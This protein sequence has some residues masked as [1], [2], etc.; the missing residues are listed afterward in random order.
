MSSKV[1]VSGSNPARSKLL[2]L[3]PSIYNFFRRR[4]KFRTNEN[5]RN[6]YKKNSSTKYQIRLHQIEVHQIR[7]HQIEVHQIEVHQ[8]GG[9]RFNFFGHI[10]KFK[11]RTLKECSLCDTLLASKIE[12]ITEKKLCEIF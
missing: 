9:S 12:K 11:V 10:H 1:E 4:T 6:S 2:K 8:I 7:L 3:I 5:K